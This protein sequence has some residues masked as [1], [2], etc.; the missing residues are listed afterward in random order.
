MDSPSQRESIF[1]W[2][3]TCV[4]S[5]QH[6][7]TGW[8][9]NV[10]DLQGKAKQVRVLAAWCRQQEPYRQPLAIRPARQRTTAPFEK[11][12]EHRVAQRALLD[13]DIERIVLLERLITGAT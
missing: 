7:S 8:A 10:L 12:A 4:Q 3:G 6:S 13:L 2:I 11:V 9:E 5:V 1:Y